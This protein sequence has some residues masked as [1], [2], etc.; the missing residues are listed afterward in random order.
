MQ[1]FIRT[2]NKHTEG[3]RQKAAGSA[4]VIGGS[5]RMSVEGTALI[6][7]DTEDPNRD[8]ILGGLNLPLESVVQELNKCGCSNLTVCY[9]ILGLLAFVVIMIGVAIG[10][11]TVNG[12]AAGILWIL[13]IL[14]LIAMIVFC[15]IRYC[16]FCQY[17]KGA[18]E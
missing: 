15:F 7:A 17:P 6:D 14:A 11:S 4:T 9:I 16:A 2:V 13:A 18:D 1:V 5:A 10:V 3:P 12:G 8:S